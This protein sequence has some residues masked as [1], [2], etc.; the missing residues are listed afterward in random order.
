MLQD[1]CK[2]LPFEHVPVAAVYLRGDIRTCR[3]EINYPGHG[4]GYDPGNS[5]ASTRDS[6]NQC[7]FF[8]SLRLTGFLAAGLFTAGLF[9]TAFTICF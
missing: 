6:L 3:K 4:G 2:K 1:D 5:G 7:V 8:I 9:A